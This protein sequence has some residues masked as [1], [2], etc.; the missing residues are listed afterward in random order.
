MSLS[1]SRAEREE[2]LAAVHLGVL[3]AASAGGTGPLTVPVIHLPAG[4]HRDR[5]HRPRHPQG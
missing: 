5:E 3:S 1:M 4:R 2:F